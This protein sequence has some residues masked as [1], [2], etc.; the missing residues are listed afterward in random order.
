MSNP[1]KPEDYDKEPG[2][3]GAIQ[4]LGNEAVSAIS[5][6]NMVPEPIENPDSRSGYLS[7][8]DAWAAHTVEHLKNICAWSREMQTKYNRMEDVLFQLHKAG[9]MN[10][11]TLDT[12]LEIMRGPSD[13][14]SED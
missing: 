3:K 4:T 8:T 7:E 5:A 1:F 6:L 2:L 14:D 11:E 13:L 10:S 12:L 9:K